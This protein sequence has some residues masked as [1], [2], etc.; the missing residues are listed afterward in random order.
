MMEEKWN[1][2][3]KFLDGINQYTA[4]TG[5]ERAKKLLEQ[6]GHPERGVKVIH[7]AGS[8]GKG[9]VCAYIASVLTECGYRTG[10]F[11]SPH[12]VDI[13][14]RIQINGQMAGREQFIN[15][16]KCV[17]DSE[18]AIQI[19]EPD[20]RLAY[21]DYLLGAAMLIFNEAQLDFV[22]LETGLGGKLD[23]SSAVEKPVLSVI[24]T[25]SLEHTAVLG[26]TIEKIAAEKAGIIKCGITVVYCC[27]NE[28]SAAV[29][30][31][32]ASNCGSSAVAVSCKDYEI[33]RNTGNNIAFSLHNE[34]YKNDCFSIGTPA[35]YQV[36]NAAVALTAIAV[37]GKEY[38]ISFEDSAVH[39][40]I[41]K[42]YWPGRMEEVIPHV[43][44]DGAH[45][46]QGIDAFVKSVNEIC[47]QNKAASAILL[48]S[49]VNDKDY[50]KMIRIIEGCS[51]FKTVLVTQTGGER[52]L[53]KDRIADEFLRCRQ[54]KVQVFEQ[55]SEAFEYG[56]AHRS[57][58]MFCA[59][60]LYLAGEI[61]EYLNRW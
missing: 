22:V 59:G 32:A 9:S 21:F 10:M 25:I 16:L 13:R 58:F 20:F 2:A 36:M 5:I 4:G 33:I 47:A 7:V 53:A 8:N 28:R 54:I 49:V 43:Y 24:T 12:L 57:D 6:L 41:S 52:Q 1:E 30:E 35:V 51:Y 14:E 38:Q 23:A 39:A 26:D 18:R 34:Y 37:L 27:D 40:G 19:R 15:A 55:V 61:K 50:E 48:F 44:V 42:M 46:P 3:V 45:N 60:S 17:R 56:L 11:T 31:N 29:I